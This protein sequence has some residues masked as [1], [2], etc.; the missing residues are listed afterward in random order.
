[1]QIMNDMFKIHTNFKLVD[2]SWV[3]GGYLRG[4][5]TVRLYGG[6]DRRSGAWVGSSPKLCTLYT[7]PG[8]HIH[9]KPGNQVPMKCISSSEI[10]GMIPAKTHVD[11]ISL[12]KE[13]KLF[14]LELLSSNKSIFFYCDTIH[15]LLIK[16]IY[17]LQNVYLWQEK[18]FSL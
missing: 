12:T 8:R 1:M 13:R 6:C 11:R 7:G 17:F 4:T 15:S 9:G 18:C 16:I 3:G 5:W 14:W 2:S 10:F